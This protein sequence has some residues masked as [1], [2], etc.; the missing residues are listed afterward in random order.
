MAAGRRNLGH[1]ICLNNTTTGDGIIAALQVLAIMRKT[2]FG[3]HELKSGMK[4]FPQVIVNVRLS[5][6]LSSL[7][8]L[9]GVQSAIKAAE[10]KLA[11]QG[12]VLL[13]PS[14]TEPLIRV[15]V[16][17]VILSIVEQ[18]AQELAQVVESA[19]R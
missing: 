9:R 19:I 16:E 12:R 15:M 1:I 3:L 2:G 13:R 4:K 8:E 18:I 10:K 17:G 14:G 7:E 5:H 6:P 11:G